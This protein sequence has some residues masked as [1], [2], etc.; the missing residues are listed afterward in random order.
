MLFV[1]KVLVAT[2]MARLHI[3]NIH[4]PNN[5]ASESNFF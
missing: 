1:I 4:E 3:Y 5:Q 2:T